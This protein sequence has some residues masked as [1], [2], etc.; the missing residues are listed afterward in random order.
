MH[1]DTSETAPFARSRDGFETL[2]GFLGGEEASGLS[3]GE[4]EERLESDGRALLRQL[5]SDHLELRTEREPRLEVV[6]GSDG[7]AHRSAETGHERSLGTV[8]GTVEWSRIAYRRS[9]SP[10]LHPADGALNLPVEHHSHGMR[11]IAAI[12]SSRGSFHDAKDAIERS[13]GQVVGKHQVEDLARRAAV[14]FVPFYESRKPTASEDTDALVISC[15]GKGIVMRP[16]A[17]RPATQAAAASAAT[18]PTSLANGEKKNR[19]RIAEVGA[20]YDVTPAPRIATDIIANDEDDPVAPAPVA[21]NKWL[22]ASVV[23]DAAIVVSQIFDEAERRDPDHVRSWVA[24]VDGAN[25]QI[26]CINKEAETRNVKITIVVDFIHVLGYLWGAARCFHPDGGPEGRRWVREKAL[27]VL[28][29]KASLVAAAIRRKATTWRLDEAARSNADECADYLIHKQA[30]LDYPTAL[31]RGWPIAS[32]VIEG[33]CRHLVADRLAIT[34]AR[35]GLEGAETI[36]KLR[37]LRSNGDFDEYWRY[38]LTMERRRV[39]EAC[40]AEHVIP[41]AA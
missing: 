14:D 1:T 11:R 28:Y 40:Y 10:N 21:K 19:K 24:L 7:V 23:E 38:H 8:F 31:E 5:Y 30:Y 17:L 32:G 13:T 16:E 2:V 4:L 33:A 22:T 37:A 25:H 34:G 35:W 27:D 15:D 6:T 9:G 12:E 18:K 26:D 41:V 3:H 39:H 29:G 20:V 36:L